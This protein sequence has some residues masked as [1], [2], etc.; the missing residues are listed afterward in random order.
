MSSEGNLSKCFRAKGTPGGN[1]SK[2]ST[3]RRVCPRMQITGK[4][5]EELG[6]VGRQIIVTSRYDEVTGACYVTAG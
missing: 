3:E 6:K 1:T 5:A 2:C 4:L